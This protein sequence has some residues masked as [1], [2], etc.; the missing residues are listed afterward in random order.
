MKK[1][2]AVLLSVVMAAAMFTAAVVVNA[3]DVTAKVVIGSEAKTST[4]NGN[5]VEMSMNG[6]NLVVKT[7]EGANDPWISIPLDSVDTS[8][9]NAFTVKFKADKAIS[10]NNTYLMDTEKNPG[11]SATA[12][13]WVPNGMGSLADGQWHELTYEITSFSVMVGTKLTGVRLTMC[14]EGGTFELESVTFSKVT[15]KDPDLWLCKAGSQ[16]VAPGYWMNDPY[17]STRNIDITLTSTSA[18]NGLCAM[19]YANKPADPEP[20]VVHI[21]LKD[22]DGKELEAQDFQVSQDD[23]GD[24]VY[25]VYFKNTHNA[26]KYTI[27]ITPGGKGKYFVLGGSEKGDIDVTVEGNFG[28]A[29]QYIHD[30]PCAFLIGAAPVDE[31][32]ADDPTPT[33]NPGTADAS[34]IAI[35]AVACIALA[36]VVV[37][38]KVR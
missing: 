7:N 30:A 12:G 4:P 14:V 17:D 34:V 22:G 23:K 27:S 2:I 31:T 35:A 5:Q 37:A 11:Y 20:C 16:N 18:F 24:G 25:S 28:T 26:G 8:V 15:P 36:G 10:T 38:K 19:M 6:S 9:Y 21:S 33:D 32:P 3:D 1:I 13:T 29:D